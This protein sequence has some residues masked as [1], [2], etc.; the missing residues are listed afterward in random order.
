MSNTQNMTK[1]QLLKTIERLENNPNDRVGTLADV[2]ITVL[3]AAGAG[4]A[5]AV[6]GTT[7]ASI[8]ILTAITGVGLDN[9]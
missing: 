7:T 4:A 5:A 9:S 1:E 6:L 3:G 2:G 8:P